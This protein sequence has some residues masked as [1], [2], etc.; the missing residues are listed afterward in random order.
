MELHEQDTH[1]AGAGLCD[2]DIV[3]F[4]VESEQSIQWLINQG[5]EFTKSKD[6]QSLH[7]TKACVTQKSYVHVAD[8]TGKAIQEKLIETVMQ[9]ILPFLKTI[10]LSI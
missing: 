6:N 3:K 7:L 5:I 10:Q 2:K 1:V 9:K 4:V 8:F